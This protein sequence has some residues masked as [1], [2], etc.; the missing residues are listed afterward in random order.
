MPQQRSPTAHSPTAS[1]SGLRWN[2]S[3][4]S[5]PQT[6]KARRD[7]DEIEASIAATE[8]LIVEV[9][10]ERASY[11]DKIRVA[12]D[13]LLE[14]KKRVRSIPN[15]M[16]GGTYQSRKNKE[17]FVR[18]LRTMKKKN[19]VARE[20]RDT[21]V[22][23]IAKRKQEISDLR[24]NKLVHLQSFA[25]SEDAMKRRAA[26][27]LNLEEKIRVLQER[28]ERVSEITQA[29]LED[30][31][32]ESA[33]IQDQCER[34]DER[35]ETL[36]A[37]IAILRTQSS[38]SGSI[39][40]PLPSKKPRERTGSGFV[41]DVLAKLLELDVRLSI[42]KDR[43][44]DIEDTLRCVKASKDLFTFGAEDDTPK[45]RSRVESEVARC[46]E[47]AEAWRKSIEQNA[48]NMRKARDALNALNKEVLNG[49]VGLKDKGD[50][51][52]KDERLHTAISETTK[53]S[54]IQEHLM[55]IVSA[56]SAL[57]QRL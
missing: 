20:W 4:L 47:E 8:K 7:L 30:Y 33:K 54:E 18:M 46:Q 26:E 38:G 11:A 22:D 19:T 5:R 31:K 23:T 13:T 21:A 52:V 15:E 24:Q 36:A 34:L 16:S 27:V 41:K 37:D 12:K 6:S 28:R 53:A 45:F 39:E 57:A 14:Q 32:E 50:E 49:S 56:T 10:K 1:K 3:A 25:D 44:N 55:R 51:D 9:R 48:V 35:I 40:Q 42:R 17:R 43:S 2:P 29:C